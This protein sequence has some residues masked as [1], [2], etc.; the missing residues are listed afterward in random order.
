[1]VIGVLN[2]VPVGPNSLSIEIPPFGVLGKSSAFWTFC[3]V[4][5]VGAFRAVGG[6]TKYQ[7]KIIY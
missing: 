5:V 2:I 3:M 6:T 1:M 4:K 7:I